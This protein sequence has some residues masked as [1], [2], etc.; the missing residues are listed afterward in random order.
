MEEIVVKI[1]KKWFLPH[2][3]PAVRVWGLAMG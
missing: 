2:F 3:N 1:E